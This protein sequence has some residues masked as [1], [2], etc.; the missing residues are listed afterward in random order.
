VNSGLASLSNVTLVLAVA[1]YALAM[2][3]YA[4]DLAFGTKQGRRT[5][6]IRFPALAGA[7]PAAGRRGR[8]TEDSQAAAGTV[9]STEPSA[10]GAGHPASFVTTAPAVATAA[11]AVATLDGEPAAMGGGPPPAVAGAP[12]GPSAPVSGRR[13]RTGPQ[14]RWLQAAFALTCAGLSAHLVSIV[15]RGVAEHRTPWGNMYEFIAAVCCMGVL[16]LV[17]ASVRFGA[18]YTG[19]FLLLPVVIALGLDVTVV[20]TPAGQLVPALQSYWIAI[21][22][23]AMILAIGF[24]LFGAVVTVLYLA[25]DRRER[26]VTAGRPP[27]YGGVLAML[28]GAVTFDRLAYRSVMVAFP[29]WMFGIFAGAMWANEAWGRPW[30]WDPKETWSLITLLV[31]AAFLHARATAGWRGRRAAFIQL[32]GFSCLMFNIVGI[33]LWVTGLHS[34]AG[35]A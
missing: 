25:A 13:A 27:G 3:G 31:Y 8:G 19:L 24:F 34:Y 1:L 16:V 14:G 21:H 9:V 32:A 23:T 18:Y 35:V 7:L 15:A 12:A 4:G 17:A 10:P 22:V 29:I 28:P 6:L 5:G 33:N 26:R 30:G 2:L 20:Y 11:T